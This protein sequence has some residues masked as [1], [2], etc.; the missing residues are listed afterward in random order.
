MTPAIV[1]VVLVFGIFLMLWNIA[2]MRGV[3][4]DYSYEGEFPGNHYLCDLRSAGTESTIRCQIGASDSAL[5][6]MADPETQAK[7]SWRPWKVQNWDFRALSNTNLRIPCTDL[8][9]RT[10][11]MFFRDVIWFENRS[12]RF[13]V[14]VPREI[15]DKLLI[16]AGRAV[17]NGS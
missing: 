14:Y 2:R 6:L 1:L 13:Y 15:G 11:K 5:Y 17:P 4:R 8:Q 12:R 10:G 3:Q 7:L 16:D 9:Y